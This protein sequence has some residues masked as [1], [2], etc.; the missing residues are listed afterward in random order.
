MKA[1]RL[2]KQ[3]QLKFL[4]YHKIEI[5]ISDGVAKLANV[6]VVRSRDLGSN[7]GLVRLFSFSGVNS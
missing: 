2:A 3:N 5:I 1:H 7:L 6:S 4:K